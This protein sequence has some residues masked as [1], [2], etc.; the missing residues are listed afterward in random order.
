[1][2]APKEDVDP[3]SSA[4]I[5]IARGKL[6]EAENVLEDALAA[7]P[8]NQE[9][10]VKLMEV[11]ASQQ[12]TEKFHQ[13]KN[14]LPA[15][16]DHDSSLGLK[17]ASLT[18]LV[19]PDE[20]D[21]QMDSGSDELSLPSEDDIFGNDQD[22]EPVDLDL[23][24]QLE[25]VGADVDTVGGD[26]SM[27]LDLGDFEKQVE[28]SSNQEE[29]IEFAPADDEDLVTQEDDSTTSDV[30][31]VS[32]SEDDGPGLSDDDA[33]TKFDLAKAYMELGDDDAAKDILEEIKSEGNSAQ[34]AEADK[35]LSGM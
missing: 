27:D 21:I 2:K 19:T 14:E 8:S 29:P 18:S 26:D 25:N 10:R 12:N 1:M 24:D 3:I 30:A 11:V 9:I 5:L 13:L 32:G 17:V 6:S 33:A 31:D 28:S 16:F 20:E 15:D 4:D 23:S 35:L 22:K 34:R 7:E